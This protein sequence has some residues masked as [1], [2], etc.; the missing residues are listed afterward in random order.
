VKD[1]TYCVP[2][3][4]AKKPLTEKV[5]S[6]TLHGEVPGALARGDAPPD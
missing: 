6:K 3:E 2:G 1:N 4:V 5:L